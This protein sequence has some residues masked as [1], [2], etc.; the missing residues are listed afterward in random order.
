MIQSTI[1]STDCALGTPAPVNLSLLVT[2]EQAI[3]EG[4]TELE[5]KYQIHFRRIETSFGPKDIV[6]KYPSKELR[7][8]EYN[9]IINCLTTKV[10]N[11]TNP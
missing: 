10:S 9:K 2:F 4:I 1:I 6:W 8:Q 3:Q 5:G 11:L 7:D